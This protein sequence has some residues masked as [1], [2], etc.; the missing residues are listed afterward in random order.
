MTASTVWVVTGISGSGKTTVGRLL[1]D[2]FDRSD[3][4]EGDV[5]RTMVRNGRRDPAPGLPG[6]AEEQLR[7]RYRHVAMLADSYSE[8]RYDVVVED[9]IVGKALTWFLDL[10]HARPLHLVVLVP[11]VEVVTS[12][13]ATRAKAGYANGWTPA[14][15][16]DVLQRE[17]PKVGLWLDTSHLTA[18]ETVDEM[19]RRAAESVLA[20]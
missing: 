6:E 5:I 12:R 4:I 19:L 9:V 18:R 11:D 1:A 10:V 17:T 15:L 13:D 14:R 16:Q 2:R 20:I 7:L 8:A 3:F